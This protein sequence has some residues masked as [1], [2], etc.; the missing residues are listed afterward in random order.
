[1]QWEIDL[2]LL[3]HPNWGAKNQHNNQSLE[4]N[5]DFM[6]C[7]W[8]ITDNREPHPG[9]NNCSILFLTYANTP[10][11]FQGD[12]L[13]RLHP[14]RSVLDS[15]C[16]YGIY[17]LKL[18]HMLLDNLTIKQNKNKEAQNKNI[19]SRIPPKPESVISETD[20]S[21]GLSSR[22]DKVRITSEAEDAVNGN[23]AVKSVKTD[24]NGNKTEENTS[25]IEE[26]TRIQEK[27]IVLQDKPAHKV[28]E[29]RPTW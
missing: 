15:P 9:K 29:V 13:R 2:L 26:S 28:S 14:E 16:Q 10:I 6:F 7:K 3:F 1:M 12:Q 22:L 17:S 8:C 19:E 5:L 27:T 21:N 24:G 18:K 11:L 25:N 23:K 20:S 4:V